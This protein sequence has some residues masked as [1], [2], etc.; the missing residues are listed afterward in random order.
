M[1]SNA[2][3]TGTRNYMWLFC[4]L[5]LGF[6]NYAWSMRTPQLYIITVTA[7]V[8]PTTT[9]PSPDFVRAVKMG[10]AYFLSSAKVTVKWSCKRKSL[11]GT[12]SNM[13][14]DLHGV[15]W[16]QCTISSLWWWCHDDHAIISRVIMPLYP[17]PSSSSLFITFH[18]LMDHRNNTCNLYNVTIDLRRQNL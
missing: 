15:C 13:L 7:T 3:N 6:Y 14:H 8:A 10:L 1:Q 5:L 12:T 11:K 4:I 16:L 9:M 2:A 18:L 17:P